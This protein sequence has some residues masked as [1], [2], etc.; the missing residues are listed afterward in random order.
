MSKSPRASPGTPECKEL[1]GPGSSP[2]LR[3]QPRVRCLGQIWEGQHPPPSLRQHVPAV[4]PDK[5]VPCLMEFAIL[6][7]DK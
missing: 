5:V 6:G 2:R 7:A 1:L 4:C 3:S